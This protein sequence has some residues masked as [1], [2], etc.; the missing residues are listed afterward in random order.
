L[1]FVFG[2]GA[3][4]NAWNP[5]L[6]LLKPYFCIEPDIDIANSFLARIVYLQ[7]WYNHEQIKKMMNTEQIQKFSDENRLFKKAICDILI[8]ASELNYLKPRESF[9]NIMR[10]YFNSKWNDFYICSTNWD[11]VIDKEIEKYL[12]NESDLPIKQ[13]TTEHIHGSIDDPSFLYLPSEVV[14]EPYRSE[15]DIGQLMVAHFRS[16]KTIESSSC[17]VIYGLSLSPLDAE[18]TQILAA[19]FNSE[20]LREIHII[21][22]NHEYVKK[23]VLTLQKPSSKIII[24]GYNPNEI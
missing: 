9:H 16:I 2:A 3:V 8:K 5:I 19:G 20:K 6:E 23:R 10:K 1:S 24:S 17:V 7:R 13:Y 11:K 12:D 15:D 21:D 18:L 22:P 14:L 4:E